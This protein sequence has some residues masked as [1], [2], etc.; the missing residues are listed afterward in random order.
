MQFIQRT[1]KNLHILLLL[2]GVLAGVILITL[3]VRSKDTEMR[4]ELLAQARSIDLALD[5]GSMYA[6]ISAQ[7]DAGIVLETPPLAAYRTRIANICSVY[8]NCRAVYLMR[9]NSKK[10]IYFLIDSLPKSST[11]YIVPGTIYKEANDALYNVFNTN[12]MVVHGPEKDR[13]GTWMSAFVPHVLPNQSMMV[14]GVDI[15]ASDWNKALLKSAILPSLATLAFLGLMMFYL[16]MWRTKHQQ[17]LSLAQSHSQLLKL[18]HED[19]LTG[20]PNRRYFDD[21]LEQMTAEAARSGVSFTVIYL[22]L[23][24]F[25]QV[26]DTLGHM[27][28]DELLR[29]VAERLKAVLRAEDTVARLAGDEFA[30]LLPRI[31]SQDEAELVAHKIISTIANPAVLQNHELIATASAGIAVYSDTLN[32]SY[33][34]LRAADEALYTAKNSGANRYYFYQPPSF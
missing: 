18:S 33:K 8:P 34:L 25:K 22:D 10:Q 26:N 27:V 5:W 31:A 15:D 19:A 29:T 28:G 13:W 14:V 16:S 7:H 32:S 4:Q 24:K 20:L 1:K 11:L 2:A 17:N 12:Q 23:D 21:K 30:M 6:D 9:Q 3:V